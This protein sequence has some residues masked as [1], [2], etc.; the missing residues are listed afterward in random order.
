MKNLPPGTKWG[1]S[2]AVPQ[3]EF[4]RQGA[5]LR[6]LAAGGREPTAVVIAAVGVAPTAGRLAAVG[7]DRLGEA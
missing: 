1:G 5:I 2:P 7:R 3:R 4:L 6:R